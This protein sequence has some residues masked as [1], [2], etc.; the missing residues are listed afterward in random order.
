MET[1]LTRT[2]GNLVN[3]TISMEMK[4]AGDCSPI[5]AITV[6]SLCPMIDV[7]VSI[8]Q[9]VKSQSCR[10]VS[11]SIKTYVLNVAAINKITCIAFVLKFDVNGALETSL[12]FYE[13]ESKKKSNL[14][15]F[16]ST[17]YRT[18]VFTD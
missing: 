12:Y 17:V 1:Q 5:T 7:E 15:R 10:L 11:I 3:Q 9:S 18:T 4:I 16:I 6:V 8:Q 14:C 2:F 13:K